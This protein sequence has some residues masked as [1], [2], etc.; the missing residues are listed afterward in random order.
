M[1]FDI[2]NIF[3][4]FRR[5]E[6]IRDE[7]SRQ[8]GLADIRQQEIA[9]LTGRAPGVG[10][11]LPGEGGRGLLA[12]PLDPTNQ[13]R[14]A[15]GLERLQSGAGVGLLGD[16]FGTGAESETD[17]A[18]LA[19]QESEFSRSLLQQESEFS[20][21]LADP[22]DV[23]PLDPFKLREAERKE[24]QARIND[25][26]EVFSAFRLDQD[27]L[28]AV[29]VDPSQQ[30]KLQGEHDSSNVMLREVNR[31]MELIDEFGTERF[32]AVAVGELAN[33][34]ADL[35]LR[36]SALRGAGAPQGAELELS[37][38]GIPD[39]LSIFGNLLAPVNVGERSRMVEAFSAFG[40]QVSDQI[41]S[42]LGINPT[43]SSTTPELLSERFLDSRG[44]TPEFWEFFQ[45][46]RGQR[47]ER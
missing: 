10:P 22:G 43:L 38:K 28:G 15:A 16:V 39:P 5:N 41:L 8:Q 31:A 32:N 3:A 13:A 2:R 37:G 46:T 6:A 20:R 25:P 7:Q 40:D 30:N 23:D 14:F 27:P 45:E 18:A 26:F 42:Q 34:R 9:G 19:Q 35:L 36:S 11:F 4:E 21:E 33:I 47:L 12:D 44:I 17:A 1:A 24:E 29:R